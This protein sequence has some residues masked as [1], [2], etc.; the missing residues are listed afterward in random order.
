M[1]LQTQGL[2]IKETNIGEND[3]LLTILTRNHGIIRAFAD[4]VRRFKGKN[5]AATC[6][7]CYADFS[8]YK[9][10]D[11][12]KINDIIPIELFFDLRYNIE[13]LSLAQYFCE[14][15]LKITPEDFEP[16]NYL[17]LMLNS[18]H[19]LV[20]NKKPIEQIKAVTEFKLASLAGFMPNLINCGGC[21]NMENKKIWLSAFDGS[22]YCSDCVKGK[23]GTV[24]INSTVLAAMRHI[25]YS[26]FAKIYSFQIPDKDLKLLSLIGEKYVSAQFDFHFKTL[27]F[28]KSI[29]NN[30]NGI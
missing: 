13:A 3:K 16:E 26:D 10:K 25:V 22:I 28:Y 17:R 18:L 12:Y 21:G 8:L 20:K 14:I 24:P 30:G 1:L 29:R 7:F 15:I 11:T 27:N 2:I 4:G 9:S 23:E 6:T 19:L 5:S